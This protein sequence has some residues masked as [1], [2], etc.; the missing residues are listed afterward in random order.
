MATAVA[1]GVHTPAATR[2]AQP[3]RQRSLGWRFVGGMVA[4]VAVI[5]C[6]TL[7]LAMVQLSVPLP[8]A[9]GF[10]LFCTFWLGGGFGLIF[11]GS[12]IADRLH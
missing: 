4:S 8:A 11:G 12:A 6:L 3:A 5:L 2:T 7:V 1:P 9:I 10:S